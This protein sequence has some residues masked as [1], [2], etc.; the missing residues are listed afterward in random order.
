M[1][2]VHPRAWK[3]RSVEESIDDM[4][5]SFARMAVPETEAEVAWDTGAL[6][7]RLRVVVEQ[8]HRYDATKHPRRDHRDVLWTLAR[9]LNERSRKVKKGETFAA[10]FEGSVLS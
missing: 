7:A 10:V 6:W 3:V 1:R 2:T 4:R 9:W 8:V 5:A